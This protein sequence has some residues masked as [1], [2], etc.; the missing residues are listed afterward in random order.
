MS[1]HP[2][3]RVPAIRRIDTD[4]SDVFAIEIRGLV[5]SADVENLFGLLEGAY[6]LHDHLD[7]LV[8]LTAFEGVDRDGL[9]RQTTEEVS[10]H[11]RAHVRRCATI[12]S[13]GEL[14]DS[15]TFLRLPSDVDHRDFAPE[16]EAAAWEWLGAR[17]TAA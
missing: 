12:G 4:R 1:L 2:L 7:L 13:Y 5:T 15:R 16:D 10:E 11:A 14:W 17:P 6:A 3:D 9:S 8:R